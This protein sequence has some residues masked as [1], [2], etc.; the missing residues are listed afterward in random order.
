[1]KMSEKDIFISNNKDVLD[2]MAKSINKKDYDITIEDNE[3]TFFNIDFSNLN[4]NNSFA[5]RILDKDD[6]EHIL[7]L[8]KHHNRNN[9]LV[10]YTKEI[11][12]FNVRDVDNSS[13]NIIGIL[14]FDDYNDKNINI[15]FK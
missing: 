13:Y 7:L 14:N 2:K 9:I 5:F 3:L 8:D 15:K 4:T 12:V 10:S 6:E 1:M 11:K